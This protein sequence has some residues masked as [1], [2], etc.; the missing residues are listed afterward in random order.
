[1]VVEH[2]P[3]RDSNTEVNSIEI[4]DRNCKIEIEFHPYWF[5]V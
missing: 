3:K 5:Y 4:D 1:M 2:A